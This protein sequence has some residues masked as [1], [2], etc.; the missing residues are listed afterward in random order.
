[1]SVYEHLIQPNLTGDLK[2]DVYAFLA[3]NGHRK[4]AEHCMKV[5]EQARELVIRL[6]IDHA[7][8]AYTRYSWN[9]KDTWRVVHP[10]LQ[11]SCKNLLWRIGK[12]AEPC[13]T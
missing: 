2:Q 4:T 6:S 7:A 12:E 8:F 3:K 11:E 10:W 9:R 5:G 1:M 13:G